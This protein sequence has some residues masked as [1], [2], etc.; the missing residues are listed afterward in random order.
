MVREALAAGWYAWIHDPM[1]EW[2]DAGPIYRSPSE[3]ESEAKRAGEVHPLA[4][5]TGDPGAMIGIDRDTG[6]ELP[7]GACHFANRGQRPTLVVMDEAG[8]L[9]DARQRV[10]AQLAVACMRRRHFGVGFLTLVQQPTDLPKAITSLCTEARV[11]RLV[12]ADHLRVV[13]R[14]FS[15]TDETLQTIRGLGRGEYV[16]LSTR[17][18]DW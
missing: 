1:N 3:F 10:L 16:T 7:G 12:D 9:D 11:F 17:P 15:C 6:D 14:R 8:V 2:S 18:A 13:Q 5:F 4:R